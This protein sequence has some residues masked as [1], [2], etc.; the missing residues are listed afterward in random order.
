M[1][2][3]ASWSDCKCQ[4]SHARDTSA[5]FWRLLVSLW[6]SLF[7]FLSRRKSHT[8]P[9]P[10]RS[11]SPTEYEHAHLIGASGTSVAFPN[12]PSGRYALRV[13][14]ITIGADGIHLPSK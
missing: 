14:V 1:I 4:A 12:S 3:T 13:S 9:P 5:A 2:S 7:S 11:D 10:I 8:D 6:K